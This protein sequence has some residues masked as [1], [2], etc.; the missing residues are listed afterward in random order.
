VRDQAGDLRGRIMA[1]DYGRR[2]IGIALTDPE[3]IIASPYGTLSVS[4]ADDAVEQIMRLAEE[5]GVTELVVGLPKTLSGDEGPMAKEVR[6]WVANL[7][8]VSDLPIHWVDERLTS[9]EIERI[10]VS[11]RKRRERTDHLAAAL[12]L[13]QYLE[14][15]R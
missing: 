11:R 3:R 9:R 13:R 14:Q 1:I 4:D 5:Q 8:E 10:P 7:S 6:G 12:I 2:H 15:I